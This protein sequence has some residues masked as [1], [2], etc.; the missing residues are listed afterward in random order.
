MIRDC[1][2]VHILVVDDEPLIADTLTLILKQSGYTAQSAYNGKEA[3]R[4]VEKF[5]PDVLITDVAMPGMS[6]TKLAAEI[7]RMLPNC[8]ILLHYGNASASP[9][10]QYEFPV[11]PK[12]SH[13]KLILKWVEEAI[14]GMLRESVQYS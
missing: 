1:R 7:S 9:R 2:T 13:P 11:L 4:A 12:P 5:L 10:L 8:R 6:G 14:S 3:L